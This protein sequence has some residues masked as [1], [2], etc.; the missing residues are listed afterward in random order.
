VVP[1]AG[2]HHLTDKL[3]WRLSAVVI[4]PRHVE[5]VN[6]CNS[7]FLSLLWL[8]LVLG[9]LLI[10]G[11]DN[12][13]DSSGVSSCR[14]VDSES[15]NRLFLDIEERLNSLSLTHSRHSDEHNVLVNAEEVLNELRVT[16]SINCRHVNVVESNSSLGLP[17]VLDEVFP[18]G[19]ILLFR[20]YMVLIDSV[21]VREHGLNIS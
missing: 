20:A 18:G 17:V 4:F 12:V 14:E 2:V 11:L 9:F 3:N 13:L 16:S 15:L 19:E 5:V 8:V 6:E 10:V 7:L 1:E 21:R